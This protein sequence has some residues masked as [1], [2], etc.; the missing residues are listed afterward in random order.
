MAEPSVVFGVI[1]PLLGGLGLFLLGMTMMSEGLCVA[2]GPALA[3][4][5]RQAT[6]GRWRALAAGAG[7]TAAVQSSSA[8]TVAT[9]GFVNAGLLTLTPAM[10]VLFGANVGTTATAWLVALVGM[11]FKIEALALPLIGVGVILRLVNERTR[12]GAIGSAV[13]G[14]GLLFLGIEW[15]QRAFGGVAV[16][17][18]LPS[19]DGLLGVLAPLLVGAL[20]TVLMQSSSASLAVA[21]S[22]AQQGLIDV[23]AAAAVVIGANL[24]TTVT[25]LLAAIGAT[26]NA[27]RVAA[28]HVAFNAITAC[29]AIVLLQVGVTAVAVLAARWGASDD[30]ALQ[31]A[32]FHSG[33][34]VLGVLLIWPLA[35][36]LSDY[37][38]QRFRSAEEDWSRPQ[39]LDPTVLAVPSLALSALTQE[40]RR[41]GALARHLALDAAHGEPESRLQATAAAWAALDRAQTEFVTQMQ[42]SAMSDANAQRLSRL[43]RIARYH[44]TC[45]EQSQAAAQSPALPAE[46]STALREVNGDF[47]HEV[48]EL[49]RALG[50]GTVPSAADA[51]GAYQRIK[52]ALLDAGAKAELPLATMEALLRARS[53][54]RRALQQAIKAASLDAEL[55][56]DESTAP[57]A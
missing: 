14:F 9:I 41:I 34:N 32:L 55:A 3:R 57:H 23:P 27:R 15:L 35:A 7:V 8:V 52:V 29:T 30:V 2:A 39:H 44:E 16:S 31:L 22:A 51:E 42:R 20:M 48:G 43:L 45:V 10:W 4:G 11:K 33:F 37:L 12:W 6:Q 18:V 38:Q 36:R 56:S 54:L 17:L 47:V 50:P 5:L 25:A 24:G 13:A 28:A 46:S 49:L 19:G 40:L 53:A 1:G 21:L 26:P